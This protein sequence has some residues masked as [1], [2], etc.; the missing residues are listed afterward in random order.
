MESVLKNIVRE[1]KKIR[2]DGMSHKNSNK[3]ISAAIKHKR[4]ILALDYE[5]INEIVDL[6]NLNEIID[7]PNTYT[8]EQFINIDINRVKNKKS[9]RTHWGKD[10]YSCFIE[11]QDDEINDPTFIEEIVTSFVQNDEYYIRIEIDKE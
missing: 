4:L 3:I 8:H 6:D 1:I 2:I 9:S 7:E 10:D 5:T 11:E